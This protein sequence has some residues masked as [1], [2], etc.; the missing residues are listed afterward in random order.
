MNFVEDYTE[1][2]CWGSKW[3]YSIIGS[4]NADQATILTH[5]CVTWP[6]WVKDRKQT[7]STHMNIWC[8]LVHVFHNVKLTIHFV[9]KRLHKRDIKFCLLFNNGIVV[10]SATHRLWY[11]SGRNM[12]TFYLSGY[13]WLFW[14]F[15][16]P[17][18]VRNYSYD[19]HL[20]HL[21]AHIYVYTCIIELGPIDGCHVR[22]AD[23]IKG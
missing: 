20:D 7:H 15:G 10:T 12:K 1:V 19:L 16:L 5:T 4:N 23:R 22:T 8:K 13:R 17:S 18:I 21:P 14:R 2:Y 3:W 11:T 6:Q 9:S